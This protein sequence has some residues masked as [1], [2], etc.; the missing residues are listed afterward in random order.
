MGHKSPDLASFPLGIPNVKVCGVRQNKRDDYI[1]TV[2]ST[3]TGTVCQHCGRKIKS[4][5]ATGGGS[6]CDTWPFQATVPISACSQ[7]GINVSIVMARP[8][9]K[10]CQPAQQWFRERLEQQDQKK[11]I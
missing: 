10:L 2:K 9:H 3:H 11:E 4:P 5:T 8:P 7:N 6:S 1:I